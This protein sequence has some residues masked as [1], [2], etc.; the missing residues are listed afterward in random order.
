M[1]VWVTDP[2][3]GG[4]LAHIMEHEMVPI[5]YDKGG[6]VLTEAKADNISAMF[7]DV[8]ANS[9]SACASWLPAAENSDALCRARRGENFEEKCRGSGFSGNLK[10][11]KYS[12][13]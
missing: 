8:V 4:T 12:S 13:R 5:A 1:R 3:Q 6:N 10:N 7:A 9:P 2:A 11:L